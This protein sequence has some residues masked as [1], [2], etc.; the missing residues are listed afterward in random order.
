MQQLVNTDPIFLPLCSFFHVTTIFLPPYCHLYTSIFGC[1]STPISCPL[2][3]ILTLACRLYFSVG[4]PHSS[5]H[6]PDLS[7]WLTGSPA[8][9]IYSSVCLPYLSTHPLTHH[10]HLL[11][12]S[13]GPLICHTY[14]IVYCAY[15]LSCH[16]CLSFCYFQEPHSAIHYIPIHLQ[17]NLVHLKT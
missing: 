2:S 11:V 7:S 4:L 8:L 17:V 1:I 12:Y 13:T 10:T 14:P 15:S 3:T 16:V 9:Q 6:L 5:D